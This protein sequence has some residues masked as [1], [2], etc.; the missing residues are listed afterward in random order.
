LIQKYFK[1]IKCIPYYKKSK[2]LLSYFS[3]RI[4]VTDKSTNTLYKICLHCDKCYVGQ[5]KRAL[6]IRLKEHESNCRN[7]KQHSAIVEHFSMSHSF[8][9]VNSYVIHQETNQ[10]D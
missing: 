7:S 5:T 4:K 6:A 3:S 10:E 8:D 1:F 2:N 9:F